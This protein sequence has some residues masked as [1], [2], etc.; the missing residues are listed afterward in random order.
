MLGGTGPAI[1]YAIKVRQFPATK[2]ARPHASER[3]LT[4]EAHYRT[5][6]ID[7]RFP[8]AH[9]R[10][11]GDISLRDPGARVNAP[12]GQNFE[13]IRPMLTDP[14]LLKQLEH[15]QVWAET[16][17]ERLKPEIVQRKKAKGSFGSVME[18]FIW[19]TSPW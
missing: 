18:T 17:F 14:A 8:P 16:T 10:R 11:S 6:Q 9:R 19:A 13:Q 5:R 1:E 15:L 3:K 4:A 12:M 2:F 7:R